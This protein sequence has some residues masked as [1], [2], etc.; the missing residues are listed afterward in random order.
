I[1]LVDQRRDE[2]NFI[3]HLRRDLRA[4]TNEMG[5]AG[6]AKIAP[7]PDHRDDTQMIQIADMFAGDVR[8]NRG[9]F[10]HHLSSITIVKA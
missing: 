4:V 3:G 6:F 7:R 2:K 10:L 8:R 5:I 1:M 9:S